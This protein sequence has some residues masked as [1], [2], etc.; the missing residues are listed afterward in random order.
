MN[1]A[2]KHQEFFQSL[3]QFILVNVNLWN[4]MFTIYVKY[5]TSFFIIILSELPSLGTTNIP[6]KLSVSFTK[7][8]RFRLIMELRS[9]NVQFNWAVPNLSILS[10]VFLFDWSSRRMVP[11]PESSE[12]TNVRALRVAKEAQITWHTIGGHRSSRFDLSGQRGSRFVLIV[13]LGMYHNVAS[14]FL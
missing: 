3:S 5:Q 7:S 6:L 10:F 11:N 12:R 2:D 13:R 8:R 9:V 14:I 4:I 1:P